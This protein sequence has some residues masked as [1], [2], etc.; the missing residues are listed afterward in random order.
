MHQPKRVINN[1]RYIED[2]YVFIHQDLFY[3]LLTD[4]Y[5]HNGLLLTSKDGLHFEFNEGVLGFDKMDT[6]ISPEI[7]KSSPNY[8]GPKFER[9]QLLLKDGIPTH[10]YAPAGVNINGGKGTCC[11]LLE[12]QN[13]PNQ[14]K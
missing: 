13:V 4:N 8:R 2:P 6:Y 11:Y 5:R 1:T 14:K 9:P 7:I 3:M 12:F 10:M